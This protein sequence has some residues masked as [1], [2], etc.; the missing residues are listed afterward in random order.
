MTKSEFVKTIAEAAGLQ[1]DD[2]N[3]ILNIVLDELAQAMANGEKVT[4]TG[5]G[6]FE[7]HERPARSFHDLRTKE[8]VQIPA[9]KLPFFKAGAPLKAKLNQK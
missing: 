5:F 3:R 4:L 7:A 1:K 8:L 2:A 9:R 6:T